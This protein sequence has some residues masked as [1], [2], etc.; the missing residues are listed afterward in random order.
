[1]ARILIA[2]DSEDNRDLLAYLLGRHGHMTMLAAGGEEVV[3]MATSE[4]P[5]LILMDLSMPGVDGHDAARLIK[6]DEA[7]AAIPILAY[8]AVYGSPLSYE[9]PAEGLFVEFVRLPIEPRT[10]VAQVE[11]HLPASAQARRA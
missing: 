7:L 6:A 8:S 5:D 9:G 10:F 2:D 1:M 3:A 4:Q 11:A